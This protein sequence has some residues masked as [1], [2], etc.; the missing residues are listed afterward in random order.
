M[1]KS[2]D[3]LLA[4]FFDNTGGINYSDSPMR[5]NDSEATG[6]RNFEY[7][8]LGGFKKKKGAGAINSVADSALKTLGMGLH[9]TA[10]DTR[11]VI[12]YADRKIQ[13]VDTA[14]PTF[15]NLTEDTA[16]AGT[17]ILAASST[18]PI[19]KAQFNTASLDVLWAAGGGMSKPYGVYSTTKVTKNGVPKPTGS[20]TATRVAAGGGVFASTGTYFYTVVYRKA[21]TQALSN[22][23]LDVSATVT[24]ATDKVTI[25]L[26]SLSNLDTTKYDKIY[27][28][29]S[30]VAG[31]S[32]FT[33]GDLVA[34]I[35]SSTTTYDDTGTSI[36][37][38]QNVPRDN[39]TVLDNGEL[40][41]GTYK[42]LTVWKRR[43]V[44]ASGSTLYLSDTIK[45]E[46]WPGTNT[47]TLPSGGPI[48]GLAVLSFTTP[49]STSIEEILC[50]FKERELWVVSGSSY[51]DWSLKFIDSVGT[52]AQSLIVA[53]NGFLFWIDQRGVYMWEGSGKPIYCSR[54][55]APLFE[56]NGDIDKSNL[57]KGW[58]VYNRVNSQI[59]WVL[60]SLIYGTNLF[61]LKMDMRLTMPAVTTS[62]GMRT[63]DAVFIPDVLPV[64]MYGGD[65]FVPSSD[66]V[67][68]AGDGTGKVYYLFN[69]NSDAG[70]GIDFQYE[71]K[72]FDLGSPGVAKRFHKLIVWV[73]D[74][75]DANLSIEFWTKYSSGVDEAT[76]LTQ[77]ISRRVTDADWDSGY[78]DS[79]YW[80]NG[81][82]TYTQPLVFNLYSSTNATEGD[83]IKFRFRQA[84]ANAP[85]TVVGYTIVYSEIALRK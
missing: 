9:V 67:F 36:A 35:N 31:S 20:F 69:S 74:S 23:A 19:V 40:P 73:S 78:W 81:A 85:V 50:V 75:S 39:N 68:I 1:R 80:D 34:Q 65:A 63:I 52:V 70:S 17:D 42:T 72:Y 53:A 24:V 84:D 21:S 13:N 46:S 51:T 33:T 14:T 64:A 60:S 16:T 15:T 2:G 5:V 38:A 32:A 43:L 8:L 61:S 29:R 26:T 11:T 59:V 44:T 27:L 25:D 49:T 45:P 83:C 10:G 76:T 47:I 71:T 56:P 18:I 41:S 7:A 57:A 55:I 22:A 54:K 66:E 48:T 12:R 28:Y 4:D 6:G 37:A 79:A 3:F 82:S 62:A 30:A 58:G 77:P